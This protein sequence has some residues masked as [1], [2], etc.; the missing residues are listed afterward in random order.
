MHLLR[1][2]TGRGPTKA[3]PTIRGD[4]V[5]VLL[6]DM[7]TKGERKLVANVHAERVLGLRH[8]FQIVMRDEFI[9]IVEGLLIKCPLVCP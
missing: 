5:T 4:L 8:K 9:A 6:A 7:L 2:F 1:E 3:K